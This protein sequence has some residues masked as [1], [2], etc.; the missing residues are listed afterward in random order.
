MGAFV[1]LAA[2]ELVAYTELAFVSESELASVFSWLSPSTTTCDRQGLD[3]LGVFD[4]CI[5]NSRA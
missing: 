2:A 5:K 3:G 1:K 4:V